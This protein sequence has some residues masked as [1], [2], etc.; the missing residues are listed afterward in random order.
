VG[1]DSK[2][3]VVVRLYR[4]SHALYRLRIPKLPALVRSLGVLLFSADISPSAHIGPGFELR[5]TV[6][7]VIGWE[8]RAGRNLIVYQNVTLGGRRDH[9]DASTGAW[10][11]RLGDDVTVGAGAAI[12][13]PVVVGDCATI[14]ANAVVTVDV[15]A[16]ATVVGIPAR[17]VGNLAPPA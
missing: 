8:V 9:A 10:T 17:V 12:L 2:V 5:H 13:G 6:G 4:F 14:G 11:P 16:G 15:P 1:A 3:P 7:V